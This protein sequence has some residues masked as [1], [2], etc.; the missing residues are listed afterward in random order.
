[1][2]I[3]ICGAHGFIGSSLT[4]Q[5]TRSGH[6]VVRGVRNA[7][8]SADVAIDYLSDTDPAVWRPRLTGIDVVINAVGIITETA[9]RRFETIHHRAPAALFAACADTGV[10]RVIQLSALGV[11]RG[12]S[13]YFRTKAAA[14]AVLTATP[15]AWQIVRPALIY[16]SDGISATFFRQLASLPLTPLPGGGRQRVQPIHIDDLCACVARLLDP[17][18]P[19][20]QIVELAGPAPLSWRDMIASYRRQMG[21]AP[22]PTVP[23][24]APLMALAA[25]VG[26]HVPGALLTPDTWRMLQAGNTTDTNAAAPLLGH[27]PR[28][29]AAFITP[30]EAPAL[31]ARALRAWQAPM[32]RLSLAFLWLFTAVVSAFVHPREASLALLAPF[33]LTGLPAHV[34]LYGASTLDAALGLATLLRPGR[35]LWSVQIALIT[36]YS[37]LILAVLPEFLWHPFGPLTKNVPI[38][39]LLILLLSEESRP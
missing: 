34:A 19:A 23:I 5:L 3:L 10:S 8:S 29:V 38:V 20:G 2:N 28:P 27:P 6:H 32:L 14:D 22:A 18:T 39:A 25:R 12:D 36:G 13:A 15:V 16:G 7:R 21:L 33:G 35:R 11:D 1:M 37:V 26:A 17:A 24:P 31:R 9:E 30:A 4:E